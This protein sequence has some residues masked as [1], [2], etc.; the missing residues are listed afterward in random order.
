MILQSE[1]HM[2]SQ[3]NSWYYSFLEKISMEAV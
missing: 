1:K 2:T 3:L